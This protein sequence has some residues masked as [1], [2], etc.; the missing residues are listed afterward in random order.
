MNWIKI[1]NTGLMETEA[2]TLLGGTTKKNSTTA[3]GKYGSGN[4]HFL[5]VLLRSGIPFKVY[6]GMKEIVIMSKPKFALG[7]EFDIIWVAGRETDMCTA[8]GPEWVMWQALR[9]V[10]ANAMDEGECVV[11]LED[12]ICPDEDKTSFF[13]AYKGEA[14]EVY[15]N[16]KDY[17]AFERNDLL[18][19][20]QGCEI[21]PRISK[22]GNVYRKGFKCFDDNLV[23]LYDYSF[24][25]IRINEER[26][27]N[28]SDIR[29]RISDTWRG[30]DDAQLLK[31]FIHSLSVEYLEWDVDWDYSYYNTAWLEPLTGH[32]LIPEDLKEMME[33]YDNPLYLPSM[34]IKGLKK[35]DFAD[36]LQFPKEIMGKLPF[37]YSTFTLDEK[38]ILDQEVLWLVDHGYP[39]VGEIKKGVIDKNQSNTLGFASHANK[40]IILTESLFTKNRDRL[41]ETII[42]ENE[43]LRCDA[44]DSSRTFEHQLVKTII[45]SLS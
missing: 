40:E 3:I 8:F 26:L 11:T 32:T 21:Y 4:K 33:G 30:V 14:K 34:M 17:F 16:L 27:T 12:S 1:R 7:Q 28:L 24:V 36:K 6:S 2:L 19:K 22:E 42:H 44:P 15:D 9:E 37:S 35:C 5:S 29:Y 43:H 41:R 31:E 23:S 25:E 39:I 38:L 20:D 10:Y 18:Y 13:I 45:E